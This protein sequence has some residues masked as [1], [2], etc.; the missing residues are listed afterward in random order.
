VSA[1]APIEI[2]PGIKLGGAALPFIVGPCMLESEALAL[3]VARH[4]AAVAA[5]TGIQVIF[6]GSFDKANRTSINS[7]RGPGLEEGLRILAS[8]QTHTGL[9]V[10]TDVHE[11]A[12]CKPAAEVCSI[13]QIPAFLCRQTDLLVAAAET[14]RTV[15]IKKGQFVAPGDM[16]HAVGKVR[17]AGN[18]RVFV[19]ERGATFGYG[20]LVVDMRTFAILADLGIH[21]VFDVTHSLQMPGRGGDTTDG[22]RRFAEP[23]AMAAVA[24]G[25]AGIFMEVH[26]QPERAL[27]DA[28]TQL[29]PDRADRLMR[30]L[31]GLRRY[32]GPPT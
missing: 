23:L 21:T 28:A 14:G 16:R 25:A 13:L 5:E 22:D 15:N 2:A 10:T 27:S 4:V 20:Q 11:I 26:P 32:L 29:P 1:V 6:K 18:Q 31:V 24:A 8:V 12:H 17:E 7:Y 19:T 30:Q 9:P 3:A